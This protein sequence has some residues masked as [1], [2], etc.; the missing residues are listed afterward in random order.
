MN[1]PINI[2]NLL[3]AGTIESERIEYKSGWNP[4]PIMKTIC[5]FAND[6]RDLNGGYIVI[7]VEAPDG[8]PVLPPKGLN[9]KAIDK[10]QRE[11]IGVTRLIEPPY[12]PISVPAS[13]QDCSLLVIYC[14]GGN[15]RPYR[16]A[17]NNANKSNK[18]YYIRQHS[19][20][21]PANQEQELEL[22]RLT[23]ESPSTT[24]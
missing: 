9:P 1:L 12:S 8:I 21:I 11:L 17:I 20:T 10:M 22:I 4:E 2:E 6:F 16:C 14:P 7:G 3:K 15:S 13:Y 23:R 5:A 24:S 19:S 18:A